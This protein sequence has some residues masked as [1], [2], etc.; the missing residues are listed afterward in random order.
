MDEN[1]RDPRT[2]SVIGAG[3]EVHRVLGRGFLEPVYQESLA[4]EFAARKI[5]F[6]AQVELPVRY[7]GAK[8]QATYRP[9]FICF[10]SVIVEIKA[11]A[12]LGTLEEAQIINYLKA[13]EFETGLLLNFGAASL[14]YRRFVASMKSA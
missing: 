13:S 4:I 3:M 2:Y 1:E 5:P 12:K 6:R 7:K 14:E 9:D 10:E 8:L 11:L